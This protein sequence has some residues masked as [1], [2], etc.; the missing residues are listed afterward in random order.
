MAKKYP[1][2]DI[3]TCEPNYFLFKIAQKRLGK[4]KN[5]V[6]LNSEEML[7]N[8][9]FR[10][11]NLP[12]FFLD[13][14]NE[15]KNPLKEE[16]KIINKNFQKAIILI[17]DIVLK[18]PMEGIN[19]LADIKHLLDNYKL[20]PRLPSSSTGYLLSFKGITLKGLIY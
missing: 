20:I 5:V 16:L 18:E 14:H 1:E 9:F 17:D 13:V 2:L 8:L 7:N 10:F 4:E 6:Y 11:G 15:G 19:H 3:W 12:F